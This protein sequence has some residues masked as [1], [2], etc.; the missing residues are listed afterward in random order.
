M[1]TGTAAA[2]E[3]RSQ[4]LEGLAGPDRDVIL[5][6]AIRRR[7]LVKSVVVHQGDPA[8]RLFLLTKGRAR[9]FFITQT[10]RK[11]LL[12][13]LPPGEVFGGAAIL[14]RPSRY[15]VSTE[16]LKDSSVLAWDRA[17]LR[18]LVTRYPTLLDNALLVSFDYFSWHLSS[19][20]AL[21]CH[22]ARE[23][24]AQV[25]ASLAGAIG[26]E[27]THGV[28]LDVTN[29]ELA[30]AANVTPFTASRLLSA[31]QRSGILTKGRGKV[32]LH[33]AKRLS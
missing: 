9:F 15:L 20:V 10:G 30:N 11:I 27:V 23:R 4:F 21:T 29:E 3:L 32:L 24:L 5:S 25:V 2:F 33:A 16:I 19:H 22:T 17:T 28:E 31:W 26:H 14:S 8:E 7:F 1:A 12:H 6:A 18:G 13:W